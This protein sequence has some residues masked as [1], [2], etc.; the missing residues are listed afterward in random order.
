VLGEITRISPP[1][2]LTEEGR[3][4]GEAPYYAFGAQFALRLAAAL[5]ELRNQP[6]GAEVLV[7]EAEGFRQ[8]GAVLRRA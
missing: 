7:E 1:T 6:S 4:Q 2:A 8:A 5:G 3:R